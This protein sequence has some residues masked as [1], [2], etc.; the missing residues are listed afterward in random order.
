MSLAVL[1]SSSRG[2]ADS[3]PPEALPGGRRSAARRVVGVLC[4][5][6]QVE[7]RGHHI[8]PLPVSREGADSS[9]QRD[10]REAHSQTTELASLALSYTVRVDA[11]SVDRARA[12]PSRVGR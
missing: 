6:V 8:V 1:W 2:V 4:R 3:D 12:W 7:A 10:D 11:F 5:S 9:L